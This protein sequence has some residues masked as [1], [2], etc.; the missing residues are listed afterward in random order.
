MGEIKLIYK[1]F[2]ESFILYKKVPFKGKLLI[3]LFLIFFLFISYF[4]LGNK[5]SDFLLSLIKQQM[6]TNIF[7]D[8]FIKLVS[9]IFVYIVY[10]YTYKFLTLIILSPFLNLYSEKIEE[11][12]KGRTYKFGFFKNIKFIF[13]GIGIS[14]T[15]FAIEL[16]FTFFFFFLGILL[17]FKIIFYT[18]TI[19]IQSFFVA[20]SFLDYTLERRE[21][22][23][24]QSLS[25]AFRS[26]FSLSFI[27]FLFLIT[28]SIP[29]IGV[30]YIPFYFTEVITLFYLKK[31][32]IN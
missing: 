10:F 27:G 23:V 32:K 24:R 17:P 30:L 31:E 15:T 12:Y 13:R 29:I 18:I 6:K 2:S 16:I 20:Y 14:F 22:G 28:F 25:E 9:K 8:V 5:F 26:F 11:F 19:M 1:S 4:F 3:P 21:F 7:A